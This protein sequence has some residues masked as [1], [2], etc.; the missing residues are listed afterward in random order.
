MTT[1][2]E[3]SV[4]TH[5]GELEPVPPLVRLIGEH[6]HSI[7]SPVDE[8]HVETALFRAFLPG[9]RSVLVLW[10]DQDG[11]P[12]A[13]AFGN[14]GSGLET[15]S[16]YL[17]INEL[18]V[19]HAFRRR[20]LAA[21]MLAFIESWAADRGIRTLACVTGMRNQAAQELYRSQGFGLSPVTWAAKNI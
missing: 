2:L 17:W 1:D 13:F 19:A 11:L 9:C 10:R 8:K 6:L 14:V 21:A 5:R 4:I 3:F 7:G 16:D 12:G 18:H 15:G 20:G